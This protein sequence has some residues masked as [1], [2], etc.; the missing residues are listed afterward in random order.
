MIYTIIYIFISAFIGITCSISGIHIRDWQYWVFILG[1]TLSYIC[2]VLS[3]IYPE[4]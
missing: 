1:V 3:K 4:D 2:G